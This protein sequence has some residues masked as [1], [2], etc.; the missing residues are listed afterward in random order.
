M[1]CRKNR[2]GNPPDAHGASDKDYS[3]LISGNRLFVSARTKS[4]S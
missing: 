2:V 3:R 1:E 4:S